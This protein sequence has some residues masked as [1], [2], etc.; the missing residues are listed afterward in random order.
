MPLPAL[1][2]NALRSVCLLFCVGLAAAV[3]PVQ[4][5]AATESHPSPVSITAKPAVKK[6]VQTVKKPVAK[7][8]AAA[9]KTKARKKSDAIATPVPKAKLDLRL[10]KAM[11][12]DLQPAKKTEA[13]AAAKP[14]L[15]AMFG[16]KAPDDGNFQLNG[17]LLSN[18]MKLNLRNEAH[19]E[20]DGAALEFQFKQ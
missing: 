3:A 1:S 16:E 20:V 9:T 15:P 4:W 12:D 19:Q 8:K 2:M 18:E 17:R 11:V 10:P 6:P 7:K 5:A 14:L 13:Q